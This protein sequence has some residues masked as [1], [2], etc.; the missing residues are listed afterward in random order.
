[1]DSSEPIPTTA[2][3]S[4]GPAYWILHYV[5]YSYPL[6][7]LVVFLSAFVAHSI[8]SSPS[9]QRVSSRS[10]LT[11]P[12]GKP[13]PPTSRPPSN[14][15]PELTNGCQGLERHISCAHYCLADVVQ[16]V[17]A[18][19]DDLFRGHV[20]D[21][22]W[23]VGKA[24]E[25]LG[26]LSKMCRYRWNGFGKTRSLLFCWLS[27]GLIGTFVGNIVNIVVH[28]VSDRRDGWWCGEAPA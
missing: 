28:A 3:S 12:G 26:T 24:K 13:L 22:F 20:C 25:V 1:M 19:E 14:G 5:Q 11:G 6:V 18:V 9:N 27:V 8:I 17:V 16:A 10:N 21:A 23:I 4:L 2:S 15:P 7:L